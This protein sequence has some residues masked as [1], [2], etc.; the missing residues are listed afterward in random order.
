MINIIG[1][2][3]TGNCVIVDNMMIDCG[4]PFNHVEKFAQ[5]IDYLLITHRHVDHYNPTTIRKI[6]EV[7]PYVIVISNQDV[8]TQHQGLVD[9]VA[10]PGKRIVEIPEYVVIPYNAP[11]SVP[12]LTYTWYNNQ[13]QH[14]IYATDVRQLEGFVPDD[15]R[16]DVFLLE[17][18]HDAEVL[19]KVCNESSQA[20]GYNVQQASG[21]HLSTQDAKSFYYQHRVS[22]HSVWY[23][24]HKSSRF[25]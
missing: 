13:A 11:H 20:F 7:N 23:R 3:S 21:R 17:A 4:L 5:S 19:Q 24:L 6:K 15:A 1:S 9:V 2:G 25:Y 8:A 16:Y 18:N 10:T 14:I 12:V 22:R